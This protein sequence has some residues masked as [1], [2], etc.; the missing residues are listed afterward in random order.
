M[1]VNDALDKFFPLHEYSCGHIKNMCNSTSPSYYNYDCSCGI[2]LSVSAHALGMVLSGSPVPVFP[3]SGAAYTAASWQKTV[4]QLNQDES[5]VLDNRF[6]AHVGHAKIPM[7]T[8]SSLLEYDC[9][10]GMILQISTQDMANALSSSQI[11][12]A[13]QASF[14]ASSTKV[15]IPSGSTEDKI[16]DFCTN[17]HIGHIKYQQPASPGKGSA[18]FYDCN[19]G[20]TLSVTPHARLNAIANMA[21]AILPPQ[22]PGSGGV[23]GNISYAPIK[24]TPAPADPFARITHPVVT[25]IETEDVKAQRK[26]DG[27]CIECGDRGEFVNMLCM[28][29]KGHGKIF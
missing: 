19:C 16:I 14:N 20:A 7:P 10:C 9:D 21:V 28:C 24:Y 26:K 1:T 5:D 25:I 8:T 22:T 4:G 18:D 23:Y 11:S 2:T 29:T 17:G 27:L 6:S 15:A 3:P 13:I 12:R